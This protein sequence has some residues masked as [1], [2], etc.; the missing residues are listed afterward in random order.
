MHSEKKNARRMSGGA[1]QSPNQV[2]KNQRDNPGRVTNW[3]G[4]PYQKKLRGQR[5]NSGER[6]DPALQN[7]NLKD[8][9][10]ILKRQRRTNS[11]LA[12]GIHPSQEEGTLPGATPVPLRQKQKPRPHARERSEAENLRHPEHTPAAHT[13]KSD[14]RKSR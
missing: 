10:V 14:F 5:K 3:T 4:S 8:R 9:G 2:L 7:K 11:D 6:E 13:E 1:P 12:L